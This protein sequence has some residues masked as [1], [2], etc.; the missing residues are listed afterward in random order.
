MRSGGG[1]GT[2]GPAECDPCP[3]R[4]IRNFALNLSAQG[5]NLDE[6]IVPPKPARRLPNS[7]NGRAAPSNSQ[8]P[9]RRLNKLRLAPPEVARQRKLPKAP[10]GV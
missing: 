8:S 1:G 3:E 5:P 4:V 7:L 2:G 9:G 10:K 6:A